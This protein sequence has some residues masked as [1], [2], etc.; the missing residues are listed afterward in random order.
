MVKIYLQC[1]KPRFNPWVGKILWR[2]ERL[3][4]PGSILSWRIPGTEDPGTVVH[5]VAKVR[6]N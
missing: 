3:P 2:R 1:R 6:P 5:V 4:T